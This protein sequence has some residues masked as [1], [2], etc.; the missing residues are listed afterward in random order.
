MT[1]TQ[2]LDTIDSL[3]SNSFSRREKILWLSRVEG[4]LHTVM[5]GCPPFAGYTEDTDPETVLLAEHPWDELY[6]RYLEM[7]MDYCNGE[8]TRYNNAA[9]LYNALLSH[10][11]N[12]LTRTAAP[13][14]GGWQ[15]R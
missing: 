5:P 14:S 7:Q 4:Y 13:Q 8:M 9:S 15:Y 3:K 2:A 12:H 1:I 6:L 11:R 10:Y